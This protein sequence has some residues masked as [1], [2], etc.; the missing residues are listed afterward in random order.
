MLCWY[1]HITRPL[2]KL[3]Y[4][5]F[6][7]KRMNQEMFSIDPANGILPQEGREINLTASFRSG[8][9]YSFSPHPKVECKKK[10]LDLPGP[11]EYYNALQ[12]EQD[13]SKPSFS[14][15]QSIN[16]LGGCPVELL[17]C[18]HCERKTMDNWTPA[19]GGKRPRPKECSTKGCVLP[20][21]LKPSTQ[22][23]NRR[24]QLW[25]CGFLT[26]RLIDWLQT[27]VGG[28]VAHQCLNVFFL[29]LRSWVF[30]SMAIAASGSS[31][32]PWG[33][34][35]SREPVLLLL[36]LQQSYARTWLYA[37]SATA[38]CFSGKQDEKPQ[39]TAKLA[40]ARTI[41]LLESVRLNIHYESIR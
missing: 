14:I 9:E 19:L 37:A 23:T 36:F 34:P 16:D 28:W 29:D 5:S 4:I 8:P 38:L 26:Q 32:H 40:W 10:T 20:D 27:T 15:G 30:S 12:D 3:K 21:L 25:N 31:F 18:S 22:H 7:P 2:Y 1:I 6:C 24:W 39:E 11:G 35:G 17:H 13:K 33:I 41:W